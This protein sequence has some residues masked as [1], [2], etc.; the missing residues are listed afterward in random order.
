MAH[1]VAQCLETHTR[2]VSPQYKL[3][4]LYLLDAI[5]KNVYSPYASVF[6][7]HVTGIFIEAY[8]AVD[9]PTRVRMEEMM[10]TWRNS[11]PTHR[12]LF[13]LVVQRNI[14]NFV[15]S[16]AHMSR[17]RPSIQQAP[18]TRITK[19]Q[20]LTELD[21]T[22]AQKQQSM[23]NRPD[24]VTNSQLATLQQLY[25]VV[26][27]SDL[28][29]EEL[30]A[31]LAQLR[32]LVRNPT[33]P[34]N[35]AP[36]SAYPPLALPDFNPSTRPTQPPQPPSVPTAPIS[37][38]LRAYLSTILPPRATP[39]Q[40]QTT[41]N[42]PL[43]PPNLSTVL[44][45]L[46][47]NGVPSLPPGALDALKQIQDAQIAQSE[48]TA[49]QSYQQAILSIRVKP[50]SA[51]LSKQPPHLVPFLNNRQAHQCQQCGLRIPREE[52]GQQKM[53][54]HLDMHFM[55]NS[56]SDQSAGRGHSRSWFVGFENWMPECK[57]VAQNEKERAAVA[58]QEKESRLK[59]AYVV[60]PVGDEAK[61]VTCPICKEMLN[62]EFLEEEEE[63]VYKNA[64]EINGRIY[65]S[66]CHADASST[67]NALINRIKQ[68]LEQR[69]RSNTPD[70]DQKRG[71]PNQSTLKRKLREDEAEQVKEEEGTP[72][73][74]KIALS[75]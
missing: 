6:A 5:A 1:V 36:M 48:V 60:I 19:G 72:P 49:L 39:V 54:D 10:R 26:R 37:A 17:G 55:Q 12:E 28:S 68:Q 62:P 75:A 42:V 9:Q 38:E 53:D 71:S 8:E 30:S 61:T 21:V 2:L 46:V 13:G 29:Q 16:A 31:I 50:T 44:S 11:S 58:A 23:R 35:T 18:V 45:S 14:E 52:G 4:A 47:K 24:E 22:I 33:P 73:S 27:A 7:D 65:H 15:S 59:N 70:A 67:P 41:T 64:I 74:K 43:I 3:T 32:N 57:S 51:E 56:R 40:F 34:Q 25:D 69:S 20:V 66:T 63:W